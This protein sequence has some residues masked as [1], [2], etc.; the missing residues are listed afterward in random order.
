[1]ATIENIIGVIGKGA[2]FIFPAEGKKVGEIGINLFKRGIEA[3]VGEKAMDRLAKD[4]I[5]NRKWDTQ[6][7][8][9]QV[10]KHEFEEKAYTR[11]V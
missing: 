1:M 3:I 2:N 10:K 7:Y 4:I 9:R 11:K 8:D 6:A 5:D